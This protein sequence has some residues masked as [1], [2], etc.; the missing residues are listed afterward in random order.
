MSSFS[1]DV[2]WKEEGSGGGQSQT[3]RL[4]LCGKRI[5]AYLGKLVPLRPWPRYL[6]NPT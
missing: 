2:A 6:Q 4:R 1:L 3:Q 5:S